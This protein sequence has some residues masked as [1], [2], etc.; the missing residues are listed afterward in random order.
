MSRPQ[1]VPT[2]Q[3]DNE[4]TRV[5]EWRF[6]TGAET[7]WHTHEYNYVVVPMLD[8]KLQIEMKEGDDLFA[9][10]KH[11]I[12]YAREAGVNHNVVNASGKEFYFIEVEFKDRPVPKD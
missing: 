3:A 8:G 4:F 9:D 7:G 5:I 1:A 12:S 10:L 6:E 11:G 2:V